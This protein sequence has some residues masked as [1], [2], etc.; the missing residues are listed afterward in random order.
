MIRIA[1]A[2]GKGGTGKTMLAT[3]LFAEMKASGLRVAIAD[4]DAE[5]PNTSLF[6]SS[7]QEPLHP[8]EPTSVLCPTIVP[9]KCTY[10]GKCAEICAFHA[11]TCI[12]N[13]KYIRLLRDIC[14]ACGACLKFCPTDAIQ[15]TRKVTGNITSY[16][17]PHDDAP[18]IFEGRVLEGEHSP[19]SV[20][21]QVIQKAIQEGEENGLDYLLMD[22]PP[23]CS[24]PFV[25]T[26]IHADKVI[27]ITEPTPFGF[28]DLKQSI[29]VL[30][31][32]EKPFS[33]VINRADLGNH[34]VQRWL[35]KNGI[36]ILAEIPFRK[37]YASYYAQGSL[38]SEVDPSFRQT[39]RQIIHQITDHENSSH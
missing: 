37:D 11:I 23:G 18:S 20:I 32:L 29:N 12:S 8:S 7:K 35:L 22:A 24:C 9:E 34:E 3:N 27:L 25:N 17:H 26:V 1:I 28:S 6:L 33:V 2:S 19:V 4:C 31:R 38:I 21:R 30:Q 36:S 15:P 13:L 14:H 39:M 16:I 10:C 5:V